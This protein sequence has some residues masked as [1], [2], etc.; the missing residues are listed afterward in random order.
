VRAEGGL[1]VFGLELSERSGSRGVR[2]SSQV[3]VFVISQSI[4]EASGI[5][6]STSGNRGDGLC[7]VHGK[8]IISNL[9][10]AFL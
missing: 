10:D 4:T 5:T 8:Q 7:Q 1:V 2:G 9:A 6:H 3:Q